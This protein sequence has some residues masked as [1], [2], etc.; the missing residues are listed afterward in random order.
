MAGARDLR[1]GAIHSRFCFIMPVSSRLAALSTQLAVSNTPVAA[2]G[3]ALKIS[4]NTD[5]VKKLPSPPPRRPHRV[6]LHVLPP[7]R[8]PLAPLPF[9][10]LARRAVCAEAE[11]PGGAAQVIN[12]VVAAH[13]GA[14][15]IINAIK[16]KGYAHVIL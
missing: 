2:E 13:Y 5:K 11:P 15:L 8:P 16:A 4:V 12:G 9:L 14:Q 7:A 1:G 3:S 10:L 6:H